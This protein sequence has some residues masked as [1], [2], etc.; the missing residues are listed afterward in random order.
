M[1]KHRIQ[2]SMLAVAALV[3]TA[4]TSQAVEITPSN[5]LPGA[6]YSG[7]LGLYADGYTCASNACTQVNSTQ[8][9]PAGLGTFSNSVSAP[10]ISD[11]SYGTLPAANYPSG[12]TASGSITFSQTPSPS[13]SISGTVTSVPLNGLIS[14]VLANS[15]TLT[16]SMEVLGPQGTVSVRVNASGGVSVSP[17]AAG[18]FGNEQAQAT[19]TVTSTNQGQVLRD[20]A[21]LLGY[22]NDPTTSQTFTDNGT[23][24][25]QTNVIYTVS[26]AGYLEADV[27][28]NLGGGTETVSAYIDPQFSIASPGAYTLEFSAGI[29]NS[30]GG[31][32]EPSTWAM[33]L[34]GFGSVGLMA[35]RRKSKPALMTA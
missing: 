13:M 32:P 35:Y 12:A 16:Y 21:Y 6:T 26:L 27:S 8:S 28:G 25:F 15:P 20:N 18:G 29:G 31:V 7:S 4:T 9:Q 1:I 11:G 33:M 22:S 34:L 23:Y 19:F 10:L 17:A 2:S 24:T 30:V 3:A 14:Q 5:T